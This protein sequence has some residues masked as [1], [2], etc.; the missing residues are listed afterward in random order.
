[1]FLQR[2]KT[3]SL[4]WMRRMFAYF[5]IL[6]GVQL[7]MGAAPSTPSSLPPSTKARVGY[8]LTLNDGI[9]NNAA[10]DYLKKGIAYAEERKADLVILELDTPGG[11]LNATRSMVKSI[12]NARVPVV[13]FVTPSGSRAGSAGVFITLAGHIAAMSPGTNIGAA[14][15]V[16]GGGKDPEKLGKHIAK[17]IENDTVAFIE[18]IAKQRKR[19]IK[20]A[21][22]AVLK[23]VSVTSDEALKLKVI[24]IIANN[25]MDLLNKLDGRTVRCDNKDMKLHTKG[26]RLAPI[27][28][29]M[30]QKIIDFLA[31]PSVF[32][33]LLMFGV[34]GITLELYHPGSFFPGVVGVVCLFLCFLAMQVIPINYGGLAMILLGAVLFFAELM[35]PTFGVLFV[36]GLISL[37]VG[38]L[39]LIDSSDP[40]M[41]LSLGTILPVI[42]GIGTLMGIAL[43]AAL[44]A[45]AKP[46]VS[47]Q[48]A[49]IGKVATVNMPLA[50]LGN[51]RLLGEQWNAESVDGAEI[52]KGQQVK[53]VRIEGLKLF[54]EPTTPKQ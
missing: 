2:Y 37:T 9:I 29:N 41:Q 52:Q 24:D 47:G 10:A 22:N 19:N 30:K 43:F 23:S 33:Y 5:M 34:L 44:R 11:A 28:M 46:K 6:S 18:A 39:F 7:L 4:V 20:W 53:I 38:S 50:P 48:E 13:V 31:H 40:S 12:L 32:Y 8:V 14:H 36:G 15:P 1:M 3:Q 25:K 51:V 42:I 35:T 45:L 26:M 17:K 54:V 21:R 16:V 27:K 49:M